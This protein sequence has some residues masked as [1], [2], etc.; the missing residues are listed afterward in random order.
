MERLYLYS[1]FFLS[2]FSNSV[3]KGKNEREALYCRKLVN[4]KIG[5][6]VIELQRTSKNIYFSLSLFLSFSLS[7]SFAMMPVEME[8]KKETETEKEKKE[9]FQ[10]KKKWEDPLSKSDTIA[11]V[12]CLMELFGTFWNPLERKQKK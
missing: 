12:I 7:L 8:K 5:V 11:L 9:E 6:K 10:K 3:S 4:T 1:F 2:H